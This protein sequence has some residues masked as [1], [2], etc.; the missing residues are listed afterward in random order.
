MDGRAY[1]LETFEADRSKDLDIAASHL[2]NIRVSA[3][4]V[5]TEWPRVMRA[6]ETAVADRQ[7]VRL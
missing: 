5:F 2:H 3:N 6:I 7:G 1:H 4:Q